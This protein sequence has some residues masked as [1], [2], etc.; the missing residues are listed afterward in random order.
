MH[1]HV[2]AQKINNVG[3]I[4]PDSI[5]EKVYN[6]FKLDYNVRVRI[7]TLSMIN[8]VDGVYKL[9]IAYQPHIPSKVFILSN[10]LVYAIS[11][12][13]FTNPKGVVA[14][15]C[16]IL[17]SL[18]LKT[19]EYHYTYIGIYRYLLSLYGAYDSGKI[20]DKKPEFLTDDEEI[21]YIKS[22]VSN[23]DLLEEISNSLR[24][25]PRKIKCLP[26]LIL[27]NSLTDE[28]VIL[29]LGMLATSVL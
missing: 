21:K 16:N 17:S 2:C 3:V 23:R 29:L 6:S 22:K 27:K 12:D 25:D 8:P 7:D 20:D 13:G 24:N 9:K 11:N 5:V 26:C 4:I 14:E 19:S 15:L 10:S 28:D 18:N 1:I